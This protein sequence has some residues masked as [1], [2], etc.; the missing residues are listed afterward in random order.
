MGMIIVVDVVVVV[1]EC[2]CVGVS[3]ER[4]CMYYAVCS[5]SQSGIRLINQILVKNH[6]RCC[7]HGYLDG[8]TCT[9]GLSSVFL[10]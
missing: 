8:Y 1:V 9:C 6:A 3:K 2:G 10:W 5:Q 7:T 4:E